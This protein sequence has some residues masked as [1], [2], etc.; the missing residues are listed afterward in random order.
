MAKN[1]SRGIKMDVKSQNEQLIELMQK[2]WISPLD[3]LAK[4][5]CMR[6]AARVL[7]IK[8]QDYRVM[9]RWADNR[10]FKEYR[11]VRKSK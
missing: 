3:A 9:D 6:L 10:K 5:G 7:D 4:V 8:N 11:I 1:E 2:Q